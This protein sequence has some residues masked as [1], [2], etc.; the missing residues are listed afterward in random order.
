[1]RASTECAVIVFPQDRVKPSAASPDRSGG[2][3]VMFTGVR[4]ERLYDLAERLPAARTG[5]AHNNRHGE[6]EYY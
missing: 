5:S 1:M 3:V 2:E 6:I 4:V